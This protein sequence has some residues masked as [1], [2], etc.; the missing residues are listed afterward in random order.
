MCFPPLDTPASTSDL[1]VLLRDP[2]AL[3]FSYQCTDRLHFGG[4]RGAIALVSHHGT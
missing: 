1:A 3:L 2:A 4:F